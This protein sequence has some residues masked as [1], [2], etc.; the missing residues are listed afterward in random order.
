[1]SSTIKN[2]FILKTKQNLCHQKLQIEEKQLQDAKTK[3]I[4]ENVLVLK[5]KILKILLKNQNR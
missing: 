3:N 4:E 1:M 2:T 5:K